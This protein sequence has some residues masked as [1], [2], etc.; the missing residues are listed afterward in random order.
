MVDTTP[1][2]AGMVYDGP[3]EKFSRDVDFI[4]SSNNYSVHWTGFKDP[5]TTMKEYFVKIGS[6]KGCDDLMAEQSVGIKTGKRKKVL[7][8]Y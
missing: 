3:E 5:H 8:R 2:S 1:P 4:I 7:K 6:C